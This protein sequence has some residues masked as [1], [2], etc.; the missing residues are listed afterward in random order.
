MAL[1]VR[2]VRQKRFYSGLIGTGSL[3]FDIG[4]NEGSRTRIF[5]ELG[6]SVVAVEPQSACLDA[7]RKRF[8]PDSEVNI[9]AAAVGASPG[10]ASLSV[11][12]DESGLATL[13]ERWRTTGRFAATHEWTRSERIDV[14]TLDA[15]VDRFGVPTFCKIDVEGYEMDV[16]RGLTRNLPCL[17]F[18][19]TSEFL[20]TAEACV[21]QRT[22][23]GH[24]EVTFCL[25][26]RQGSRSPG[27]F[28]TRCLAASAQRSTAKLG[29]IYVRPL[30]SGDRPAVSPGNG[31]QLSPR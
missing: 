14:T 8:G 17:S 29:D 7:L 3:C 10:T 15:L 18:E 27:R 11:C 4:A 6:A 12:P 20:E 21:G 5:R 31:N 28:R 13:S 2:H 25:G 9:V 16:L 30:A 26:K 1:Q 19:F 23:L 24:V 22:E